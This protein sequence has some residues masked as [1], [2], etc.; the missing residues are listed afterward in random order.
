MVGL[1]RA[2]FFAHLDVPMMAKFVDSFKAKYDRYPSDWAVMEY[3]AVYVLKQSYNF[4]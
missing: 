3:D 4:V 1:C 2:P